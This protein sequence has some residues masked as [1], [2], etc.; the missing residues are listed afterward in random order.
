[1]PET[2]TPEMKELIAQLGALVKKDDRCRAIETAIDEYEHSEEL[3]GLIAEY[4]IQQNLLAD[5]H[6]TGKDPGEEFKKN[7]GD[8]IN[9]L[10]GQIV[11]H[12]VYSA[13]V[14]AKEDF[15]ELTNEIFGELQF[16]ITGQRPCAHDCSACHSDCHHDHEH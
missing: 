7:V 3:N 14:M 15:D 2:L 5:A 16:V 1:M 9:E 6:S 4:N 8:R 13:Y 11:A 10:Y 12:P